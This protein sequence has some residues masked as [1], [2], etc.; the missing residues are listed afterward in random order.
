MSIIIIV[1]VHWTKLESASIQYKGR[2]GN[3][4]SV[5]S[6]NNAYESHSTFSSWS[7]PR[8]NSNKKKRN[9]EKH[10]DIFLEFLVFLE[11]AS[12]RESKNDKNYLH[13]KAPN[14]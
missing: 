8:Y 11:Q 2:Q 12:K 14:K 4:G 6:I 3:M 5:K 13:G 1:H 10:T 7:S 9:S